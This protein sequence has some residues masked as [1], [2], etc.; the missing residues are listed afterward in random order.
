M[1]TC[2][3]A[4]LNTQN[5]LDVMVSNNGRFMHWKTEEE[6]A[7]YSAHR[8]YSYVILGLLANQFNIFAPFRAFK[9]SEQNKIVT[10]LYFG[11][12]NKSPF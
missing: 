4:G 8:A 1:V 10:I 9:R 11:G 6:V 5:H 3:S 12:T 7:S 2:D